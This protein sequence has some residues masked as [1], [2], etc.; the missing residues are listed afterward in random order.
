MQSHQAE[1]SLQEAAPGRLIVGA[2][3]LKIANRCLRDRVHLRVE[4]PLEEN[5]HGDRK[6]ALASLEQVCATAGG[7]MPTFRP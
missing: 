5:H 3:H 4:G 1:V 7:A 6:S 2:T